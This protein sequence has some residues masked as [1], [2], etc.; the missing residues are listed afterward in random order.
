MRLTLACLAAL[1][2]STLP[3]C[4]DDPAGPEAAA[5]NV[6]AFVIGDE[7][8]SQL[9]A[10]VRDTETEAL[11]RSRQGITLFAPTNLALERLGTDMLAQFTAHPDVLRRILRRHIVPGAV[12]VE[13]LRDGEALTPLEGPPLSVRVED[14]RVFVGGAPLTARRMDFDVGNGVVHHLGGVVRDHLTLAERLRVTPLASNFAAAFNQTELRDLLGGDPYTLVVPIENAFTAF[15]RDALLRLLQPQN[16]DVLLK[17]LRHHVLPGRVRLEDLNGRLEVTPLDGSPLSVRNENGVRYLGG[18]RVIAGEVEAADGLIYFVDRIVINH[19]N[20]AERVQID[21]TLTSYYAI[22]SRSGALNELRGPGPFTA[23]APT[24]A[25]L[26][27]LGSRFV[28]ILD[29]R[30]TLLSRTAEYSLVPDR[31]E[32]ADLLTV[33]SLATLSG[34]ALPVAARPTDDGTEAFVG[35]RGRVALPP[36]EASNGLLYHLSPFVYPPG[37]DLDGYAIFSGAL[38]FLDVVQNAGLVSLLRGDE[39]YTIFAPSDQALAL[40]PTSGSNASRI[41]RAHIV[42]GRYEAS[43]LEGGASLEPLSGPP[44]EVVVTTGPGAAMF[45][46]GV[47]IRTYT[48][49]PSNGV[50][51]LLDGVLP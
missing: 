16:R 30:R 8:L 23:F 14:G 1:L 31:I 37:M 2:V 49:A 38:S 29:T 17:V 27:V 20:L 47:R 18:A 26:S 40:V 9:E 45:A 39:P 32:E 33:D 51:Y 19:L 36:V 10:L 24:D 6:S 11:L 15:G 44:I 48:E 21:P 34:Y 7:A 43:D 25:A 13:D 35:G 5:A 50:L 28:S 41:A 3:A 12:R 4:G 22:L 46:N 42:P